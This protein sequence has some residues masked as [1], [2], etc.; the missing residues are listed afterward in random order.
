[1]SRKCRRPQCLSNRISP[2][3]RS[4]ITCLIQLFRLR[5]Q[6]KS[7]DNSRPCNRL[8]RRHDGGNLVAGL[9][10]EVNNPIGIINSNTDVSRQAVA[11]LRG[12]LDNGNA[13]AGAARATLGLL[14]RSQAD[15]LNLCRWQVADGIK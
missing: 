13:E 3:P 6:T 12:E 5:S 15:T 9:A 11:K 8:S 14:D 7:V 10:H 2:L 4:Q 1:M